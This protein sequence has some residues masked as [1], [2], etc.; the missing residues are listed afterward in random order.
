MQLFMWTI[1]QSV[2]MQKVIKPFASGK[3]VIIF[4]IIKKLLNTSHTCTTYL[5]SYGTWNIEIKM[6]LHLSLKHSIESNSM[7]RMPPARSVIFLNATE[8]QQLSVYELDSR[9]HSQSNWTFCGSKNSTNFLWY[10][11]PIN[12]TE[13]II[14]TTRSCCWVIRKGERLLV[15]VTQ[16]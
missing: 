16:E 15:F 14:F 11:L 2:S 7:L 8:L 5:Q 6:N 10:Y 3:Y 13:F 12:L 9:Y 4:R 1:K